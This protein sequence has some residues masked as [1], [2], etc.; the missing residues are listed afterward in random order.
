M[1][2]T[3][4]LVG[5]DPGWNDDTQDELFDWGTL[6][7]EYAEFIESSDPKPDPE[8]VN[9]DVE[10]DLDPG[11]IADATKRKAAALRYEKKVNKTVS[12]LVKVAA[13]HPATVTD[14]AT[15]FLY[16]PKLGRAFGDLAAEDERVAKA[17]EWFDS[18]VSNPYLDAAAVAVPIMLQLMRNHEVE[19]TPEGVKIPFT[20]RRITL[21]FRIKFPWLNKATDDPGHL[22]RQVF[23][24]A[25]VRQ[26]MSERGINVAAPAP[27]RTRKPRTD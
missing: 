9:S 23:G 26:K 3:E 16:G 5:D 17:I 18:G 20:K 10:S 11:F 2:A 24:N 19:A 6:N 12:G 15:L 27:R 4:P 14:A 1:T 25:T 7:K 21:R 13:Q 22:Y 8:Y